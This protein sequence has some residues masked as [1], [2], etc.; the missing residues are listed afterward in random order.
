M[1]TDKP[2]VTWKQQTLKHP[3]QK[4]AMY[5]HDGNST[6]WDVITLTDPGLHYNDQVYSPRY[7]LATLL[8]F[9]VF[10]AVKMRIVVVSV[11]TLFNNVGGR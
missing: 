5:L 7:Q 10:T 1:R 3:M 6:A 8:R 11:V 4:W 9:Q 2:F